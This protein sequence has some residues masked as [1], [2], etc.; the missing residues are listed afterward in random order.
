MSHGRLQTSSSGSGSGLV[1]V[2]VVVAVVV[3]V[4]I[5]VI[6]LTGISSGIFTE[7]LFIHCSRS[8][9]NLEMLVFV[10][11]WRKTRDPVEKP[12]GQG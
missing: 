3:V 2:L 5:V 6:M 10:E 1:V 11:G 8:N 7:W 12:L 4:V 9:F